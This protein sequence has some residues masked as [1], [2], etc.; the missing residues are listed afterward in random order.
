MLEMENRDRAV[1][2]MPG[3]VGH[4]PNV[5]PVYTIDEG[6]NPDVLW[7]RLSVLLLVVIVFLF[8][9]LVLKASVVEKYGD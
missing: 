9:M 4:V 6:P 7:K 3:E 5:V 2:D 1:L 8:F